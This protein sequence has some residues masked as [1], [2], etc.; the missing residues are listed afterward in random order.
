V[1]Q[2][3]QFDG[4][5]DDLA[6]PPGLIYT[7]TVLSF[8]TWFN[9]T[10][11]GII[12]GYQDTAYPTRPLFYYQ[13][14]IYV[15]TDGK[16]R[17]EFYQD[18]ARPITTASPVNDG[19][20]HHLALVA[21]VDQQGLFLDGVLVGGL[22]GRLNGHTQMYNQIGMGWS[23]VWPS[24]TNNWMGFNGRIDEPSL[25]YRALSAAEIQT[26][27][28]AGPDGKCKIPTYLFV[29][30]IDAGYRPIANE[31]VI[32]ATVTLQ[33]TRDFVDVGAFVLLDVTE[34]DGSTLTYRLRTNAQSTA[35][36]TFGTG[37]AG[38]YTFTVQN[39]SEPGRI[40]AP[41]H[42]VETSDSITIPGQ[43]ENHRR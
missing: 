43:R 3:F 29:Q 38:T 11:N 28:N 41:G 25:Y 19:Q 12:L 39:V 18:Q 2:A 15:G 21:N 4:S 7:H 17:A 22:S 32:T 24:G 31:Y 37:Q 26:I 36:L 6:L 23:G 27:Y 1:A 16:L 5:D 9:S 33:D 34:P 40:Y 30:A 10:G 13:P 42:N 20:W 14:A 35:S 8:E